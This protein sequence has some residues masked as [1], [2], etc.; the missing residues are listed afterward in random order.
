MNRWHCV[1]GL[2]PVLFLMTALGCSDGR[3]KMGLAPTEGTVTCNGK[4]VPWVAVFFEP[5]QRGENANVGKQGIGHCDEN[6]HFV[7]STYDTNDGAVVGRHQ[8]KVG[9]PMGESRSG[10]E[11]SCALNTE[12]VATEIDVAEGQNT[13]EIALKPASKRA[14]MIEAREAARNKDD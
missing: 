6:G 4:P 12:L 3:V 10:F 5:M 1:P 2:I 13:F 14:K 7:I 11:C 9:P 8:V